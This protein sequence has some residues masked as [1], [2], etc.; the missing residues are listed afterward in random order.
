MPLPLPPVYRVKRGSA[1]RRP[2]R[3]GAPIAR[4]GDPFPQCPFCRRTTAGG[5]AYGAEWRGGLPAACADCAMLLGWRIVT[6]GGDIRT[7]PLT[8]ADAGSHATHVDLWRY[9]KC[10]A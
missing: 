3:P 6:R 9:A 2:A 8:N 4:S 10:P 1:A 5:R 7:A